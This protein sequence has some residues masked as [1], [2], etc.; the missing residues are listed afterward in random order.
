[1]VLY[2][3]GTNNTL[4]IEEASKL[5]KTN[6]NELIARITRRTPRVYIK[7]NKVYKILNYL[8]EEI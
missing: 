3:D 6:K 2:G 1:M 4:S 5:G 7:D 8:T